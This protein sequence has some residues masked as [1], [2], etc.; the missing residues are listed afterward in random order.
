MERRSF[1][2][3]LLVGSLVSAAAATMMGMVRRRRADA[4]RP[5]VRGTRVVREG[6][7]RLVAWSRGTARRMARSRG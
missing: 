1:L 6:A 7:E 5:L 2:R 3:G 4:R